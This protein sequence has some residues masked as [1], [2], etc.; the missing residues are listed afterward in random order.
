M[1]GISLMLAGG[2]AV[3]T[4]AALPRTAGAQERPSRTEQ[5]EEQDFSPTPYTEYAEFDEGADEDE[6]TK[7]FQYGRFFG[8]SLGLGLQNVTGNRG[9][10]WSGGFPTV[11]FRFHYWFD[12]NFALDLGISTAPHSFESLGA[13]GVYQVNM[14]RVGTD[15]KY[16]FDTRDASAA[17]ASSNPYVLL[18]AGSYSKTETASQTKL[19]DN[20]S[21]FG[22]C[23]GLGLEFAFKARKAYFNIESKFH[24]V[25]FKDTN[26]SKFGYDNLN[27]NFVTLTGS[28]LFTW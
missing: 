19:S 3:L 25:R 23:G 22:I 18:G 12:F 4:V 14:I 2:L 7:F 16:Y 5:S 10:L 11:D 20:D 28:F 1:R 17:W 27:G 24:M 6:E 15:A 8:V 21:S 26:A 9:Q 13:A